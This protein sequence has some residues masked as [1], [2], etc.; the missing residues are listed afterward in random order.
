[1]KLPFVV[2]ML[3][4][5]QKNPKLLLKWFSETVGCFSI[6]T[7]TVSSNKFTHFSDLTKS[8]LDLTSKEVLSAYFFCSHP[9]LLQP[10]SQ[11]VHSAKVHPAHSYSAYLTP[12]FSCFLLPYKLPSGPSL[13]LVLP[14]DKTCSAAV[15]FLQQCKSQNLVSMSP[16]RQLNP[17]S[18]QNSRLFL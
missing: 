16:F 1:M 14:L 12:S 17:N 5:L 10:V 13:V 18:Q 3:V 2:G 11:T 8:R 4:L 9:H 15:Q 6:R 7:L